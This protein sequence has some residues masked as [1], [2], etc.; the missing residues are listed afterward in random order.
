MIAIDINHMEPI[1]GVDFI[2]GDFLDPIVQE[3][4]RELVGGGNGTGKVE[5]VL[6]DMMAPMTGVR[7]KD[8]AASLDLVMAATSFALSTLR[9]G[10]GKAME[11]GKA[12]KAYDGGKMV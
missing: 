1:T 6:S 12:M 4:V 3:R 9:V 11:S 5:T 2:Q 10:S 8:V 7:I